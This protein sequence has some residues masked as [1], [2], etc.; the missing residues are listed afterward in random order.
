MFQNWDFGQMQIYH[1]ATLLTTEAQLKRAFF[2]PRS[3]VAAE[4][5]DQMSLLKKWPKM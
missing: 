2:P 1:L 5:G 4:Q 3:F